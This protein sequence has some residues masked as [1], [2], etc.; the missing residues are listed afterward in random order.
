M[1]TIQKMQRQNRRHRGQASLLQIRGAPKTVAA[2]SNES[3]DMID[4]ISPK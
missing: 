3:A 1:Y 2:S 4:P